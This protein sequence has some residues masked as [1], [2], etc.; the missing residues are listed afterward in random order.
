MKKRIQ[1]LLAVLLLACCFAVSAQAGAHVSEAAD[2][3][4]D[5]F[6]AYL[7]TLDEDGDGWVFPTDVSE[8]V[9]PGWDVADVTGINIFSDIVKLDCSNNQIRE[10]DL[11]EFVR[12]ERLNCSGN[13]LTNL[14]VKN[15]LTLLTLD[16][17]N[18][19]LTV[20]TVSDQSRLAGAAAAEPQDYDGSNL[21][22]D[23][24]TGC[25]ILADKDV[26]IEIEEGEEK[27]EERRFALLDILS[28]APGSEQ[29]AG[30]VEVVID[31]HVTNCVFWPVGGVSETA[32]FLSYCTPTTLSVWYND[33]DELIASAT[34]YP[35]GLTAFTMTTQTHVADLD[36]TKPG[37]YTITATVPGHSQIPLISKSSTVTF[38]VNAPPATPTPEPTEEPTPEPTEEPTPEPTEEP[39]PEPTEEPTPE[40]TEEPTPTPEPTATPE[41]EDPT[42]ASVKGLKYSLNSKKKTAVF[43]QPKNRKITSI[44]VPD[45]IT[46]KNKTYKVTEIGAN[47]CKG[48]SKLTKVSIGKN[49]TKI[50][51][52]AFNTC[53][54]LKTV[55]GGTG[56]TSVGDSAFTSCV[57]LTSVPA[58]PKLTTIGAN[59]FKGCKVLPKITLSAKVKTI[60]KNA[61][62]GCA[63]LKTITIKTK[64]LKD[65]TVG[66]N[67][68]KGIYSKP[69]VTCPKGM[70]KT[71]KK[72]LLKKGMP[73][74]AV[75][76]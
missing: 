51:K 67:A 70:A 16:I 28:P 55:A 74:K 64:L 37:S 13:P 15:C 20:L 41:P 26:R 33:E 60:G 75:F 56:V 6:R 2:F 47:A 29:E 73:K 3:P 35:E 14:N 50:G 44:T 27:P 71:Y 18:T 12:L 5:N 36:L 72:L 39:T 38:T 30:T 9:F 40:P 23:P 76:K 52:N 63:K 69:T 21:W 58:F 7:Q 54:A 42:T 8:L 11:Q 24:A 48:M 61:F 32:K 53:N 34:I 68:F 25:R 4:D 65:K 45:T 10:L 62:N 22:K 59:A 17:R 19:D 57:K 66:A 49:V 46:V 1:F 31:Y 43:T